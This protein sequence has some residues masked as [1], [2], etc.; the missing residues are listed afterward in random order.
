MSNTSLIFI[1]G[2]FPL[3]PVL[4]ETEVHTSPS[5]PKDKQKNFTEDQ[6]KPHMVDHFNQ[7][8]PANSEC[9]PKMGKLYKRWTESLENFASEKQGYRLLEK[10][11]NENGVPFEVWTTSKKTPEDDVISWDSPCEQHNLEGQD[12]FG[13]GMVMVKDLK[14]LKSRINKEKVIL[15]YLVVSPK[16]GNATK[17]Y[18]TLRGET[19]IYIEND[20]LIYQKMDEGQSYGLSVGK[21]GD[22]KVVAT[23]TPKEFPRSI[24]CPRNLQEEAIR[25]KTPK[26]LYSGFY[27][28]KT[29]NRTTDQFDT[30]MVGWSCN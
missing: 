7:G 30:I 22:L 12:K 28:Q 11:R 1:L 9:S 14:E 23:I 25:N 24:D 10:F 20:N 13:I 26:N 21:N 15:R 16:N 6:F 18:Q 19:P 17:T 3:N 29:W 2:L 27:C 5:A 8:C 4:C